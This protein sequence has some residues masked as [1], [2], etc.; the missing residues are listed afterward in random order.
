MLTGWLLEEAWTFSAMMFRGLRRYP[1]RL[2]IWYENAS[3]VSCEWKVRRTDAGREQ[4]SGGSHLTRIKF[5]QSGALN[6]V[7]INDNPG[8]QPVISRAQLC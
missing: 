8:L 1:F 6:E 5:R 7:N 3:A 4:E 2:P